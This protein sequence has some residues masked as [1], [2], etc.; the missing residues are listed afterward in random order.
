LK[1]HSIFSKKAQTNQT[2]LNFA[3][4]GKV[5]VKNI[6]EKA[7][8]YLAR[9]I[10]NDMRTLSFAVSDD[11]KAFVHQLSP[12]YEIPSEE[13]MKL[14]LQDYHKKKLEPSLRK[15]IKSVQAYALTTDG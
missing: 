11:F 4:K 1:A 6:I 7:N 14:I 3:V 13:T 9:V 15:I 10:A 8:Y 2:Q 5:L 12:L